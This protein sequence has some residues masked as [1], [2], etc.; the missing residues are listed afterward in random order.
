MQAFN[1]LFE[2]RHAG[3]M[4]QAGIDMMVAFNSLFEMRDDRRRRVN[5]RHQRS[6]NSLFEM[7]R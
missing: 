6:F 4:A 2:M 7:R 3:S 1:S 5:R